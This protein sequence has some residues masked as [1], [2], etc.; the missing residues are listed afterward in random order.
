MSENRP[1]QICPLIPK[2]LLK[3]FKTQKP[4]SK[5]TPYIQKPKISLKSKNVRK[6]TPKSGHS[7]SKTI[8]KTQ[9]PNSKN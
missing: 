2:Q 3:I 8:Y 6:E 7:G 1:P 9:K 5:M 4:N